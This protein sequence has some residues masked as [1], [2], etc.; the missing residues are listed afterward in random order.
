MFDDTKQLLDYLTDQKQSIME[1]YPDNFSLIYA[2]DDIIK[3]Y[4]DD[5]F[6]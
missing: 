6:V 4:D 2:I 1:K 5:Y 3:L